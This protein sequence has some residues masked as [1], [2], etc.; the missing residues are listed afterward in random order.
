MSFSK[1]KTTIL[2]LSI[3]ISN[4]TSHQ[5]TAEKMDKLQ[6]D[7]VKFD[8]FFDSITPMQNYQLV[9]HHYRPIQIGAVVAMSCTFIRSGNYAFFIMEVN[10]PAKISRVYT[11]WRDRK[12]LL[13]ANF[14]IVK[15]EDDLWNVTTIG[16]AKHRDSEHNVYYICKRQDEFEIFELTLLPFVRHEIS[17]DNV[18]INISTLEQ[19]LKKTISLI[20]KHKEAQSNSVMITIV[21]CGILITLVVVQQIVSYIS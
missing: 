3:F 18:K 9:E 4:A 10:A 19:K 15:S 5:M 7:R 12:G 16:F 20:E 21:T 17:L 14:G 13:N 6:C 11:I 1:Q 2:I 8:D